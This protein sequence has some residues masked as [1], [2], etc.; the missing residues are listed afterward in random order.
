MTRIVL[1]AL[2]LGALLTGAA[3]TNGGIVAAIWDAAGC[4]LD[5]NG[6]P[7]PQPTIDAGCEWDPD[8]RCLPGS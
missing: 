4:E 7:P 5:P 6:S 2:L 1:L 8:G 3:S